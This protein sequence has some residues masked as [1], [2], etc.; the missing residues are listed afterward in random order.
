M[1]RKPKKINSSSFIYV[2]PKYP[3]PIALDTKL[4]PEGEAFLKNSC[5]QINISPE[6]KNKF[7]KG[8][9]DE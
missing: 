1:K 2:S 3:G 4:S 8:E 7:L 9:K 6:L 5:I